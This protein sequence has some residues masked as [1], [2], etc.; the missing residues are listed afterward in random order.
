MPYG[1]LDST[2]PTQQTS[3]IDDPKVMGLLA[4]GL[5]VLSNNTGHYGAF[6]PPVGAGGLLGLQTATQLSSQAKTFGLKQREIDIL[7]QYRTLQEKQMQN[8][9]DMMAWAKKNFLNDPS[10]GGQSMGGQAQPTQ[11]QPMSQMPPP[12]GTG[13]V[14]APPPETQAPQQPQRQPQ[15][16]FD[17][18]VNAA[19]FAAVLGAMKLDPS[20]ILSANKQLYPEGIAQRE[21]APIVDPYTGRIVAEAPLKTAEGLGQRR[22]AA[23]QLEYYKPP[24][25]DLVAQQAADLARAKTTGEKTAAAPLTMAPPRETTSGQKVYLTEQ[26][27]ID[28]ARGVRSSAAGVP[29]STG[30]PSGYA[31]QGPTIEGRAV[32]TNLAKAREAYTTSALT[33]QEAL[34]SIQLMKGALVSKLKTNTFAPATSTLSD[35]AYAVGLKAEDYNLNDPTNVQEFTKGSRKLVADMTRALSSREAFQGLKFIEQGNPGLRNTVETNVKLVS[36]A[37]GTKLWEIAR[38]QE[39]Q[40]WADEHGGTTDR[41][42]QNFQMKNPVQKFWQKSYD[43]LTNQVGVIARP[44]S[45]AP[46]PQ[47]TRLFDPAPLQLNPSTYAPLKKRSDGSYDYVPSR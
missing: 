47:G 25:A 11:G 39:A 2:D 42:I 8:Q 29:S 44:L 14:L 21:G 7:D 9:L 37:E 5:G 18:R 23:G 3:W 40:K 16:Q 27:A 13:T 19:K 38:D 6:A 31:G 4:A 10:M 20:A 36:L 26:Q 12:P 41:F 24:G 33:A 35:I 43:D 30:T 28:Q 17:P 32:S 22:N 45:G 15:Q 46:T 1:L 34:P